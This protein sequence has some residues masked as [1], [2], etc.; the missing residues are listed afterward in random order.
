MGAGIPE[1]VFKEIADLVQRVIAAR[2]DAPGHDPARAELRIRCD[3]LVFHNFGPVDC[4]YIITDEADEPTL[5]VESIDIAP[6][7][8]GRGIATELLGEIIRLAGD[9]GLHLS[10]S[11]NPPVDYGDPARPA[12][13]ERLICFYERLGFAGEV[14]GRRDGN[15]I[16]RSSGPAPEPE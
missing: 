3:E 9:R 6:A 2:P 10:L 16:I 15:M 7:A 5:L 12:A 1:L 14:D 4:L 8:R 13:L 11:A